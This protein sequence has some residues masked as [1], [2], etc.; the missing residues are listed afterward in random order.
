MEHHS[1]A[2]AAQRMSKYYILY[3]YITNLY[4]WWGND[5]KRWLQNCGLD[6]DPTRSNPML[7][8]W[9]M[10]STAGAPWP[11]Q[12][13]QSLDRELVGLSWGLISVNGTQPLVIQ[14]NRKDSVDRHIKWYNK[15]I[16]IYYI[17]WYWYPTKFH[18]EYPSSQL[19]PKE[20][21]RQFG[22]SLRPCTQK[23]CGQ[24]PWE[25]QISRHLSANVLP[26]F[27]LGWPMV[28]KNTNVA[29]VSEIPAAQMMSK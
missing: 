21:T 26:C 10:G 16:Y 12:V 23:S 5:M 25:L 4:L 2:A 3:I 9:I 8:W 29:N 18:H 27:F 7:S 19:F 17:C 22:S 1:V 15:L 24:K 28:P 11:F 6:V 20:F 13:L 14:K